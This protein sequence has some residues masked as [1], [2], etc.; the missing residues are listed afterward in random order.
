MPFYTDPA[1]KMEHKFAWYD[2]PWPRLESQ[3]RANFHSNH[4][5]RGH[6]STNCTHNDRPLFYIRKKGRPVSQCTQCRALRKNRSLHTRCECPTRVQNR[7]QGGTTSE[8]AD[9]PHGMS[10]EAAKEYVE[11]ISMDQGTF[12]SLSLLTAIGG[13]RNC[14]S[15]RCQCDGRPTQSIAPAS[16]SPVNTMPAGSPSPFT[17][18]FSPNFASLAPSQIRNHMYPL[19]TTQYA[20]LPQFTGM[21]TFGSGLYQPPQ[22]LASSTT[23]N[24]NVIAQVQQFQRRQEHLMAS[25]QRRIQQEAELARRQ[26][27]DVDNGLGSLP[28]SS[29]S[30]LPEP[31]H[32]H[33]ASLPITYDS[34]LQISPS[35]HS[36]DRRLSVPQQ[37][38]TDIRTSDTDRSDTYRYI[39]DTSPSLSHIPYAT[40]LSN[41]LFRFP[42]SLESQHQK[43][44]SASIGT[45]STLPDGRVQKSRFYRSETHAKPSDAPAD[46]PH[47]LQEQGKPDGAFES[48]H[49]GPTAQLEIRSDETSLGKGD[50]PE[51]DEEGASD[52]FPGLEKVFDNWDAADNEW[53]YSLQTECAKPGAI[54]ECGDSCC[55]PGCF[56]HTNNP[57]DQGVYNTML[58][59]LGSILET[60]QDE[61]GSAK[62]K[63]CASTL[64]SSTSGADAKL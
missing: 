27:R 61:Q 48:S 24:Q 43:P 50:L 5:I 3:E 29:Q 23:S 40:T 1:T 14:N 34:S 45:E 62:S 64:R 22:N 4:C 38:Y 46:A 21:P 26:S 30:Q 16:P 39:H 10:L 8:L 54:C 60:E 53:L 31:Y 20:T 58:N 32:P 9:L 17:L 42:P 44:P 13:C 25:T 12:L 35:L 63:P 49:K 18:T 36:A 19:N 55:C 28:P 57:G 7:G 6:R 33:R 47:T 52:V 15:H 11:R 56:T 2:L 41:S 51:L 59:K 37:R